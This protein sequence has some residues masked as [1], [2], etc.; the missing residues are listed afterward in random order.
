MRA[1]QDFVLSEPL[2]VDGTQQTE[3]HHRVLA[4]EDVVNQPLEVEPATTSR[5]SEKFRNKSFKLKLDTK[6][7]STFSYHQMKPELSSKQI[8]RINCAHNVALCSSRDRVIRARQGNL[9]VIAVGHNFSRVGAGQAEG[10]REVVRLLGER[11]H[12]LQASLVAQLFE[13]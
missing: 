1:A 5:S 4:V 3:R 12:L 6:T 9:R 2:G 8:P 7:N 13:V 11:R 10:V